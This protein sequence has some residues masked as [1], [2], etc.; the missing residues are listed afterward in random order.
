MKLELHIEELVLRG[1]GTR[2]QHEIR[3]AMEHELSRLFRTE[4]VAASLGRNRDVSL[5][6]AGSFQVDS[7]TGR[8][9]GVQLA[10]SIYRRMCHE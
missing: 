4:G 7:T 9:I 1:I 5:L 3:A 2:R 8:A 6:D 10:S